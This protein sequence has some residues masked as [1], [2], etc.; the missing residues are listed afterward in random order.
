MQYFSTSTTCTA[1]NVSHFDNITVRNVHIGKTSG[2]AYEIIGLDV[3]DA[4]DPVPIKG[5]TIENVVV[6]S[7]AGGV[8]VCRWADVT[9]LGDNR[10]A[11]PACDNSPPPP[12]PPPPHAC[13]EKT[14]HGC[15]NDSGTV[16][17]PVYQPQLHDKVTFQACASA[18]Y[19]IQ[20]TLAGIDG[21]NHCFC[22]NSL[23]PGAAGRSRPMSE[24]AEN[25]C[26]ANS[27][28]K[29]CGGHDR[30]V[31][32]DFDCK[33]R[34][35]GAAGEHGRAGGD[36][37]P[38][39]PPP[40]PL[41]SQ[42][43]PLER[44]LPPSAKH[45]RRGIMQSDGNER[46]TA[47]TT[48][49]I[50]CSAVQKAVNDAISTGQTVYTLPAGDI[51]C[52]VDFV[53]LNA[54]NMLI[55]SP[56]INATTFWFEPSRAGF[57]IMDSRDVTVSGITIDHDPLPYIQA[58]IT[59]ITTAPASAP[60]RASALRRL[61]PSTTVYEF[62]LGV[63]S[64]DFTA[65]NG[66]YGPLVQPKLW[67]GNGSDRWVKGSLPLPSLSTLRRTGGDTWTTLPGF[68]P[69]PGAQVGD[70]ITLMLRQAHTYVVG[71][72]SHVVTEDVTIYSAKSLNFYELDGAGAHVY[73]RVRVTRRDQQLIGS[74]ADCFH[75]IDVETGPTVVDSE[76]SYC[77]D[78]FFNIHNT[79]HIMM[80][81]PKAAAN[82]A[83]S[84]G[85]GATTA[86]RD[87]GGTF[88]ATLINARITDCH[89]RPASIAPYVNASLNGNKT[90][91]QWYGDTSPMSNIVAG[92]DTISCRTFNTFEQRFGSAEQVVV[93]KVLV[94]DLART[95]Y[96]AAQALMHS[97]TSATGVGFAMGW[98]GVELWDIELQGDT[99][100]WN[101]TAEPVLMCDIQRFLGKHALIA[102]NS[103]HHTTCN[104]GRVKSSDSS[105]V[106][107][108]FAVAGMQNL[109]VTG[110]QNWMEGPMLIS[111]VVIANN[112]FLGVDKSGDSMIHAS[113]QAANITVVGNLPA[114]QPAPP[115]SSADAFCS[116]SNEEPCAEAVGGSGAGAGKCSENNMHM[117]QHVMSSTKTMHLDALH[118]LAEGNGHS[119]VS[120]VGVIYADMNGVPGA[121]LGNTATVVVKATAPKSFVELPFKYP[122]GVS[123]TPHHA[124]ETLWMGE[125]AAVEDHSVAREHRARAGT[126]GEEELPPGPYDLACFGFV[127]S[128]E[129]RACRFRPQD[130]NASL[131]VTAGETSMCSSSVSIYATYL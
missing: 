11:F 41:P 18:C 91:D 39:P 87:G 32:F 114:A 22:G 85:G 110:L 23:A 109:E 84:A 63:R 117:E 17:L 83:A 8:G 56:S 99:S 75:S 49:P 6:D 58:E 88:A 34:S 128:A 79:I 26:H 31:V 36:L 93:R 95:S 9:A 112:T 101:T 98:C 127:P 40:P 21:G 94:T 38:P 67:T 66:S 7:P 43:S 76:L 102:N 53:V 3:L 81:T 120:V 16:V 20:N 44:H 45:P 62:K 130:F 70:A 15:Y 92:T 28:E 14:V 129:H 65:L 96:A 116:T 10:P 1:S 42:R 72:S 68:A 64:L 27:A 131:P 97:V 19:G 59:S 50:S 5:I 51:Y 48:P 73:R 4:A 29:D 104:Y 126:R 60:G 125:V 119:D 90:L 74:N 111:N 80:P 57:R 71:N 82:R 108:T 122:G 13:T 123:I 78:D 46:S 86:G 61:L 52:D 124:G 121:L 2:P 55:Q 115:P 33:S 105:V 35:N 54:S 100:G 107:S 30:M 25:A 37:S 47:S 113:P 103:F 118:V 24:C 69:M 77:L 106:N 12:P 89:S